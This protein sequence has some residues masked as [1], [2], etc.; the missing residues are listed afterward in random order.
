MTTVKWRQQAPPKHWYQYGTFF[1]ITPQTT[2]ISLIKVFYK[3]DF[4]KNQEFLHIND[5]FKFRVIFNEAG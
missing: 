5:F 4:C 2:G 1:A 3:I